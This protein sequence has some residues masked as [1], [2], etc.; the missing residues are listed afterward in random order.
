MQNDQTKP[1][2][3]WGEALPDWTP[4]PSPA[5]LALEGR[6][7]R[8]EPLSAW[9]H[10]AELHD[11]FAGHDRLWD[12]MGYGPFATAADYHRWTEASEGDRDPY[13]LVL[14]DLETGR[15]SGVASFL[16]IAPDSGSVEV[17]HICISPVLQR[18]VAVTEAMHLMMG[19]A[20]AAG[21]RR[22]EWKCNALNLPSRSA[23]QRL[24]F[25]FEG[26]F[27]QHMIV[28]GHSRDTAWFS[29]ID[30]EWPALEAAHKAWLDPSNFDIEDRQKTRL[31][32]LTR[33]LLAVRDPGLL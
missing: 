31:S 18:K 2:P 29:V 7:V 5:S 14:R 17:G 16:R 1:G 9:Q 6:N 21:Y 10:A 13:F 15:A 30:K 11:S 32:D 8:L 24:G 33:P 27:R 26:V 3:V 23:A 12:Y 28:K 22:Y 20:F 4:P 19:W 25:S